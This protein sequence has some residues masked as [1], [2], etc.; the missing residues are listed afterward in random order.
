MKFSLHN[1]QKPMTLTSKI[2]RILNAGWLVSDKVFSNGIVDIRWRRPGGPIGWHESRPM[3]CRQ[4]KG[5]GLLYQFVASCPKNYDIMPL[6]RSHQLSQVAA[7]AVEGKC[8]VMCVAG[9]TCTDAD[10]V[11]LSSIND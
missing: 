11:Q 9:A 3:P 10:Q 5:R 1:G 4:K 2:E 7:G 6:V 8:M